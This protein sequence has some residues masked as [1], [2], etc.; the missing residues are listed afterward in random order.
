MARHP[1]V[2]VHDDPLNGSWFRYRNRADRTVREVHFENAA[3]ARAK[4]NFAIARGLA[5]VGIWTLESDAGRRG[6]ARAIDRTFVDPIGG[7]PRGR[8][9]APSGSIAAGS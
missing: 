1:S 3:S 8:P 7:S 4:F 6:M 9:F 5:G 2:T